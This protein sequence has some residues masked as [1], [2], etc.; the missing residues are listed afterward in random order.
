MNIFAYEYEYFRRIH[1]ES[2]YNIYM[3]LYVIFRSSWRAPSMYSMYMYTLLG[4]SSLRMLHFL[5]AEKR[6]K[7]TD[8][9]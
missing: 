2:I 3:N 7:R 5:Q 4:F 9:I 8:T 6:R 1:S